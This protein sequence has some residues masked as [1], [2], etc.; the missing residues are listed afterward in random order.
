MDLISKEELAELIELSRCVPEEFQL[1]CFAALLSHTLDLKAHVGR[2]VEEGSL[3]RK[4]I[5]AIAPRQPGFVLPID[6]KAFLTQYDLDTDSLW[7]VFLADAGQVRPLYQLEATKKVDAQ[8]QHALMM[9]LENALQTGEFKVGVEA[10]RT[11]CQERKSYDPKNYLRNFRTRAEL[12]RAVEGVEE[13]VLSPV[14]KSEL[15]DLLEAV[16]EPHE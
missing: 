14:G 13:L 10:L 6:V 7:R 11:R 2:E 9:A 12:F 5:G 4:E 16:A 15:A 1:E 8:I 3:V